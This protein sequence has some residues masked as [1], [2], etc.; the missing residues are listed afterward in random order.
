MTDDE[1]PRDTG[2]IDTQ[3]RVLDGR[4]FLLSISRDR[5][6]TLSG[7]SQAAEEDASQSRDRNQD[8]D[9]FRNHKMPDLQSDLGW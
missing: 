7:V 3:D 6:Q 4:D 1:L 9:F 2:H 8:L 5:E